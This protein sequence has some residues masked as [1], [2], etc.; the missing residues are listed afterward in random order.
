MPKC[1][2]AEK[3][4][5]QR[6]RVKVRTM[7]TISKFTRKQVRK[8]VQTVIVTV[9]SI[10]FSYFTW[11]EFPPFPKFSNH[12]VFFLIKRQWINLVS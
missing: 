5:R 1:I 3:N 2:L 8:Y 10:P 11:E 12:I 9:T 4:A 6:I 7:Y